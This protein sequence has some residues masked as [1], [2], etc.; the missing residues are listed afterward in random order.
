LPASLSVT[1]VKSDSG[2]VVRELAINGVV[3]ITFSPKGT[4][5]STW[6]RY[7]QST[8]PPPPTLTLVQPDGLLVRHQTDARLSFDTTVKPEDPNAQ[9]TNLRIFSTATGEEVMA[10]T[11]KSQ[12]N[13]YVHPHISLVQ[14]ADHQSSLL[15]Y[16]AGTQRSLL[17]SRT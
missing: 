14:P 17:P 16:L 10:F 9:H 15:S 12:E 5:L 11:N 1:I 4:Y 6:E 8:S 13:W 3:E 7:G 2:E